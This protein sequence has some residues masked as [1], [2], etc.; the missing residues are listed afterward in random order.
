MGDKHALKHE[1]DYYESK[2]VRQIRKRF[3]IIMLVLLTI[4]FGMI[5]CFA[6]KDRQNNIKTDMETEMTTISVTGQEE[7]RLQED[8]LDIQESGTGDLSETDITGTDENLQTFMELI[9][10]PQENAVVHRQV[11]VSGL[12]AGTKERIALQESVFLAQLTAFLHEQGIQ[13]TEVV[14]EKEF[15]TSSENVSGYLFELTGERDMQLIAF[16]FPKLQGQYL[17]AIIEK[18]KMDEQTGEMQVQ[19]IYVEAPLPVQTEKEKKEQTYDASTLTISGIPEKLLNYLDNRY[20][21]QYSLYDYLYKNGYR[22]VK[23]V[24]VESY[25]IDADER[26]A[27]MDI[28]LDTGRMMAGVYD[29]QRNSYLFHE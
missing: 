21:F 9:F 1:E 14:M 20:E 18:E 6:I 23:E 5:F 4:H 7:V 22:D 16:F 19:N 10:D 13:T 12:S 29:K 17:F 26:K 27:E 25:T 28:R 15:M 8:V 11:K 3:T 2:S 24:M